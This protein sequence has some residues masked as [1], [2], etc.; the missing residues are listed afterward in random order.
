[1]SIRSI[2][3]PT[4][5]I[6]TDVY[7]SLFRAPSQY[8]RGM[9]AQATAAPSFAELCYQHTFSACG[10]GMCKEGDVCPMPVLKLI[11]H[12]QTD[13]VSERNEM[14]KVDLDFKKN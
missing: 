8:N 9:S 3:A 7:K 13:E 14:I 11:D 12:H 5:S 4:P 2:D 6:L 10:C 1:M